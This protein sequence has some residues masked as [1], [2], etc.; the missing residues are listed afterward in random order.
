MVF[1]NLAGQE[2]L[3]KS[4][5]EGVGFSRTCRSLQE[6]KMRKG[7]GRIFFQDGMGHGFHLAGGLRFELLIFSNPRR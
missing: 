6:C 2:E 3:D 7:D 1:R 4:L 5:R